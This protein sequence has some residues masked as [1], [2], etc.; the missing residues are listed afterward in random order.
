MHADF[1]GELIPQDAKLNRT[2]IDSDTIE[3][4]NLPDSLEVL[5]DVLLTG[6]DNSLLARITDIT[7][8]VISI[9]P[10][11][12]GF[13]KGEL[14]INANLVLAGHGEIKPAKILG[15][16]DAARSN[17]EFILEVDQVSFVPDATKNSGVA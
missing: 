3:L 4:E 17:Q 5:Q 9:E 15:S 16:G 13:N 10:K 2:P 14:V 8:N 1:R 6:D 7:G 11:A 12:T